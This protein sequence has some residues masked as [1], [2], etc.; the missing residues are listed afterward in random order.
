MPLPARIAVLM[1]LVVAGVPACSTGT[2]QPDGTARP[3]GT[4]RPAAPSAGSPSPAIAAPSGCA[5]GRTVVNWLPDRPSQPR[6]CVRTGAE[7][8]VFL[9]A[10]DSASRWQPP[11]SSD[12]GVAYEGPSGVSQEGAVSATVYARRAGTVLISSY[13]GFPRDSQRSMRRR[14]QL[15]LDVVP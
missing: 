10:P 5:T 12:P 11:T 8:V 4:A 1:T 9:H 7:V 3:T 13:T 2:T 6:L 15:T 14:W